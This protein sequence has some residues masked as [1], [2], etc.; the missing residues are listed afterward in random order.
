MSEDQKSQEQAHEDQ[1][2]KIEEKM[3]KTPIRRVPLVE[4]PSAAQIII[5]SAAWY[6]HVA[7]WSLLCAMVCVCAFLALSIALFKVATK[8]PET[9]SYLVDA[10]G[11][12]LVVEPLSQPVMSDAN[13]LMWASD[14]IKEIHTLA[15]TDYV[16]HIMSM[17]KD[18]T[19]AAFKNFQT[20]II[21]SKTIE[22]LKTKRLLMHMEPI[23]APR[24]IK[25]GTAGGKYM[26]VIQMKIKQIMEG[27][28][29]TQAGNVLTVTMT[30]ERASRTESLSGLVI[31]QYLVKEDGATR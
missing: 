23:E 7:K 3:R 14:R 19:P 15:F 11:R 27:G 1:R 6:R 26:W 28:D 24:I 21:E 8:E 20:S 9:L 17:K 16:D 5:D 18:F 2:K 30:A 10:D 13:I 25:K 22:K 4:A 31:N 29:Y 12:M